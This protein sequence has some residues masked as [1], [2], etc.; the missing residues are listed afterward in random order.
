MPFPLGISV[1]LGIIATV[2]SMRHFDSSAATTMRRRQGRHVGVPTECSLHPTSDVSQVGDVRRAQEGSLAGQ[3]VASVVAQNLSLSPQ[4]EM[5]ESK[6]AAERHYLAVEQE[7]GSWS[8][9]D[10]ATAVAVNLRGQPMVLL[11]EH[12]AST[13]AAFLNLKTADRLGQSGSECATRKG[14][15]GSPGQAGCSLGTAAHAA[16]KS[17]A[18]GVS[19]MTSRTSRRASRTLSR[20]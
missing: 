5:M 14:N 4:F 1:V 9:I 6:Q 11:D 7:D 17:H 19:L 2:L 15:L 13:L 8:V 18:L 16:R 12:L 3:V 20:Q 10:A